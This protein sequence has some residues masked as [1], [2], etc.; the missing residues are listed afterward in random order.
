MN[1]VRAHT[2]ITKV[3][4]NSQ[5]QTDQPQVPVRGVA[6]VVFET[7]SLQF[8]DVETYD[9]QSLSEVWSRHQDSR[10]PQYGHQA[11]AVNSGLCVDSLLPDSHP[12]C[13][14]IPLNTG[15]QS[16]GRSQMRCS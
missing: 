2:L 1:E 11:P 16:T 5:L 4:Q 10:N 8:H 9:N 3:L 7:G 13:I 14:F 15:L 6:Q 12:H